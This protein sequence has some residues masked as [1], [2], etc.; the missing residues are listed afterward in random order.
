[1]NAIFKVKNEEIE[2]L[3]VNDCN[4]GEIEEA[5]ETIEEKLFDFLYNNDLED[6]DLSFFK[7]KLLYIDEMNYIV[8]MIKWDKAD[9]CDC[10]I[11]YE[12]VIYSLV[13]LV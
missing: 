11:L 2:L 9:P 3:M 1:M 5:K 13:S 8:K 7:E 10:G 12:D 4:C 6:D